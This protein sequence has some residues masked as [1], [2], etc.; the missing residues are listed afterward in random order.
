M[1]KGE[2]ITGLRANLYSLAA[3]VICLAR[4]HAKRDHN[5]ISPVFPRPSDMI[6][7]LHLPNFPNFCAFWLVFLHDSANN[8]CLSHQP[9]CAATT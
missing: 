2:E 5:I 3:V 6:F 4:S 1:E 9:T 7:A 8:I